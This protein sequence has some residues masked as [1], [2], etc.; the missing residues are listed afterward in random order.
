ME[1]FD[2]ICEE[3]YSDMQQKYDLEK[4][5]YVGEYRCEGCGKVLKLVSKV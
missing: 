2:L 5:C 4:K 1:V 3:C